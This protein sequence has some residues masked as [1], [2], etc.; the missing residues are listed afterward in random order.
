MYMHVPPSG[1][2]GAKW[3]A[4]QLRRPACRKWKCCSYTLFWA[5]AY[6]WEGGNPPPPVWLLWD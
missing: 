1:L 4:P 3:V 6:V 5:L 2:L